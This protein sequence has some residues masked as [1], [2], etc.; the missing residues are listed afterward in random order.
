VIASCPGVPRAIA[1]VYYARTGIYLG[2][3]LVSVHP[4]ASRIRIPVLLISGEQDWIVPTEQARKIL[5]VLPSERKSLVV[6]PNAVH[7]T[8]YSAAPALYKNTALTFLD[9]NLS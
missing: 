8:T 9:N 2:P 3:G 4:S 7:D 5:S 6:L 1:L